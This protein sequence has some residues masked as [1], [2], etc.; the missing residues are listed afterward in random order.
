MKHDID[1]RLLVI[2]ALR[3]TM[4]L[5]VSVLGS[6]MRDLPGGAGVPELTGPDIW[7]WVDGGGKTF[8]IG[9]SPDHNGHP[10]LTIRQ[11]VSKSLGGWLTTTSLL[12]G[13]DR[14]SIVNSFTVTIV[15]H[16]GAYSGYRS[17]VRAVAKDGNPMDGINRACEIMERDPSV[18]SAIA[19]ALVAATDDKEPGSLN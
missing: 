11:P 7:T 4:E 10:M 19:E 15:A 12:L 16:S 13:L 8:A 5:A 1:D 14:N 2:E 18:N 17:T 3:P 6:M 9:R